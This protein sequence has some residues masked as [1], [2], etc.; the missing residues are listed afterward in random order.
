MGCGCAREMDVRPGDA[1]AAVDECIFEQRAGERR[2][3][4]GR[5]DEAGHILLICELEGGQERER[6]W[7]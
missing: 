7:R 5:A 3:A 1:G 6:L 4:V 2:E